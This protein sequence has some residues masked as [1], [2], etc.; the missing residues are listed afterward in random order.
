MAAERFSGE[1]TFSGDSTDILDYTEIKANQG[2]R[3]SGKHSV[4]VLFGHFTGTPSGTATLELALVDENFIVYERREIT[5]T[6]GAKRAGRDG[7]SG[8]YIA[9]FVDPVSGRNICD[10]AGMHAP[11]GSSEK[12]YWKLGLIN[13]AAV[14]GFSELEVFWQCEPAMAGDIV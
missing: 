10:L 3:R 11:V 12:L 7:A 2:S 9:E 13:S 14:V 4:L 1:A 6:V 5:A 8:D